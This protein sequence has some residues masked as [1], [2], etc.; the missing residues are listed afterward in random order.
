MQNI[1]TWV[2]GSHTLRAGG[3]LRTTTETNTAP[4]NYT[5]TFTF[6]GGVAPAI[7]ED[8]NVIGGPTNISSIESYRRTLLLQP[9][10]FSPQRVRE[11]GGGASQF[12][13]NSGDPTITGG[14][15][16]LGVFV[17]DD[18]RM[19]PNFTLNLGLR[20]ETQN[21]IDLRAS[22]GPRIGLAWAPGSGPR[23]KTVIRAGTG[24]FYSRFL[25]SDVLT[26]R[27]FN[28]LT[29]RQISISKPDFFPSAPVFDMTPTGFAG[30]IQQLSP[31]LADVLPA[32]RSQSGEAAPV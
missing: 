17:A 13:Q 11:L 32:V 23:P 5:G 12:T 31:T 22:I 14:Q 18:W 16:D 20:V 4:Q 7:D 2:H 19:R 21:N 25:L 29:Q 27:R 6:S 1:T 3:R 24:L 15:T 30:N 28:G 9:L 26:A 10:G 8:G